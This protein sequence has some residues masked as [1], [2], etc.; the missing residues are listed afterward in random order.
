LISFLANP[1][2]LVPMQLGN[3]YPAIRQTNSCD[4]FEL[5]PTSWAI[6]FTKT[7]KVTNATADGD[8]FNLCELTDDLKAHCNAVNLARH[9]SGGQTSIAEASGE[10]CVIRGR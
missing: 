5:P 10:A 4:A 1:V 8:G 3:A 2:R 7:R 9:Y 6:N